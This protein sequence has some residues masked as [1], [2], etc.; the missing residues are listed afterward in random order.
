MM[1][2]IQNEVY[3]TMHN[4][5]IEGKRYI[6]T[7]ECKTRSKLVKEGKYSWPWNIKLCEDSRLHL[8]NDI[9]QNGIKVH[10]NEFDQIINHKDL[11]YKMQNVD[12][13]KKGK[14]ITFQY[15]SKYLRN[16]DS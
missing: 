16:L 9:K 8:F 12:K 13:L 5:C 3:H 1:P 14:N 4:L 7:G 2:L 11:P 6:E 10:N 15:I